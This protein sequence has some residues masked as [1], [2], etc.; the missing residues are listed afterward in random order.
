MS[1][2]TKV[3]SGAYKLHRVELTNYS[4]KVVDISF[5]VDKFF[6]LESLTSMFLTYQ[7]TIVDAVNLLEKYLI[8]GNEKIKLVLLKRDAP[9]QSEVMIEK[10]LIVSGIE[11]YTKPTNETQVYTI[12]AMSETAFAAA[13]SRISRSVSGTI[14]EIIGTL[15]GEISNTDSLDTIDDSAEGNFKMVLPNLP[16]SKTFLL[17]LNK[18]Q[19][20]NGTPF[21]LYETLWHDVILTSYEEMI[22]RTEFDTFYQSSYDNTD[23]LTEKSF[24]YNRTRIRDITSN[25]GV[26]TFEGMTTGAYLSRTHTIDYSVKDYDYI[27]YS[28]FDN[29]NIKMDKNPILSDQL[30]VSN[31]S[32]T[33]YNNPKQYYVSK[34]SLSFGEGVDNLNNRFDSSVAYKA[35]VLRN[36]YALSHTITIGGDTRVRVGECIRIE[37]PSANDP[38][39]SRE[40]IVDTLLSGNYIVTSIAHNFDRKESYSQQVGIR[41]DSIDRNMI[42]SKNR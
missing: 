1:D 8:T 6:V 28:I 19:K 31:K 22:G 5:L 10:D 33:E 13:S 30:T 29:N 18:C 41:K 27:D 24:N 37:L 17:L 16:Y 4:G 20:N 23:A 12:K 2:D 9:D 11:G 35:M 25:L 14:P 36:Q 34:N 42:E 32:I 26:S 39:N 38:D 3:Q 15:F 7:F 21:Y 40:E